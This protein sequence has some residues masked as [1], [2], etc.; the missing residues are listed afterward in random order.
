M[1]TNENLLVIENHALAIQ[2]NVLGF[3][4][5]RFE[6]KACVNFSSICQFNSTR[7]HETKFDIYMEVNEAHEVNEKTL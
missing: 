4:G 7:F 1:L 3:P 2:V 5:V 6:Q